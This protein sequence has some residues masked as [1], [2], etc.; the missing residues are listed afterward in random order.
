[1]YLSLS[2]AWCCC[3]CLGTEGDDVIYLVFEVIIDG[4]MVPGINR[5][6][7]ERA[8]IIGW[9]TNFLLAMNTWVL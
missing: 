2:P 4:V 6:G 3:K 8:F 5:L 9:G 1:M 7:L